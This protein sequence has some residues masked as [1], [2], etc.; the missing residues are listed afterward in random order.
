MGAVPVTDID[1]S[2]LSDESGRCTKINEVLF[3]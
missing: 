2:T 1:G 3:G